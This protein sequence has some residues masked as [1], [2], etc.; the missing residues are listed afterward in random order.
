MSSPDPAPVAVVID[1]SQPQPAPGPQGIESQAAALVAG[2][3]QDGQEAIQLA[4][5]SGPF[6]I[7]A[8]VALGVCSGLFLCVFFLI[9]SFLT[10]QCGP[11]W[12]L[13]SAGS[14]GSSSP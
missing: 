10:F 14:H 2:F 6:K 3:T 7:H 4:K 11:S 13:A 9:S 12:V 1:S 8:L 5:L